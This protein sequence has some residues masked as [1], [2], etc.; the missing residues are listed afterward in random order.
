MRTYSHA[1]LNYAAA[2]SLKP[3]DYSFAVWAMVGATIPDLPAAIGAAWLWTQK[4]RYSRQDFLKEVC[5]REVF[6]KPDAAL[7]SALSVAFALTI[8]AGL[9][10][11]ERAWRKATLSLLLGW[12]GHVATDTLTHGSD[13]RPLL[14]LSSK[15]RFVS[16]VS[17]RERE[18]HGRAFALAEH[19]ILLMV[20]ARKL[21]R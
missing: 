7:H 18:R 13:A 3:D 21:V 19:A 10:A 4:L 15:W 11:K 14:W 16:P 6:R 8:Y 5:G 20:A 1:L 12:A 17:Y 2:R 9:G